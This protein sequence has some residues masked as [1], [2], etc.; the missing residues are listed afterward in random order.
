MPL[1]FAPAPPV[2]IRSGVVG[3]KPSGIPAARVE[4]PC[5]L[6]SSS[7]PSRLTPADSS[8][9]RSRPRKQKASLQGEHEPGANGGKRGCLTGNT[10]RDLPFTPHV[11]HGLARPSLSDQPDRPDRLDRPERPLANELSRRSL[12]SVGIESCP[13]RPPAGLLSCPQSRRPGL[14]GSHARCCAEA[15]NDSAAA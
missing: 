5:A 8:L 9:L 2:A 4:R 14:I 7:F 12:S 15:E 6:V 11:L 1:G 13:A 3:W 10:P